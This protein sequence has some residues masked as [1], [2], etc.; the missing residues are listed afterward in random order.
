M[1]PCQVTV[2][3]TRTW[4]TSSEAKEHFGLTI[5]YIYEDWMI[6]NRKIYYFIKQR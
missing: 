6:L 2:V 3:S 4:T 5:G 1:V